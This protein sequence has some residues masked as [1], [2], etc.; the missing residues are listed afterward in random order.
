MSEE[1]SENNT[2][3]SENSKSSLV[4]LHAETALASSSLADKKSAKESCE[5]SIPASSLRGAFAAQCERK[6]QSSHP[7]GKKEEGQAEREGASILFRDASLLAFPVRSMRGVF[8]WVSSPAAIA[9]LQSELSDCGQELTASFPEFRR[10][11]CFV[12]SKCSL[13]NQRKVY[14]EEY[15]FQAVVQEGVD[16]IASWLAAQ[17][18]SDDKL[19]RW[20]KKK[21]EEDLV[22]LSEEDFNYFTQ[23]AREISGRHAAGEVSYDSL[24]PA[25]SVFFTVVRAADDDAAKLSE[26]KKY[27][28]DYLQLGAMRNTAKGF[29]RASYL[30]EAS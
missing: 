6:G 17:V 2:P 23:V 20:W 21:L 30:T 7:F 26:L 13:V 9:R 4:F 1:I 28:L 18:F 29:V 15:A 22:I 8:T 11:Q 27:Q 16:S 10:S 12:G 19:H 25:E 3:S 5:L 14:L 24:I